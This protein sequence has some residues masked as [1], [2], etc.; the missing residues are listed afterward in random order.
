[1]TSGDAVP[2][3]EY[4]LRLPFDAESG[5][6]NTGPGPCVIILILPRHM[7]RS[8]VMVIV[9]A[10]Q[11]GKRERPYA[12]FNSAPPYCCSR[13]DRQWKTIIGLRTNTCS[14]FSEESSLRLRSAIARAHTS[15]RRLRVA[16]HPSVAHRDCESHRA[17]ST[18]SSD[19]YLAP[20]IIFTRLALS[21]VHRSGK[22]SPSP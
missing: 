20:P 21:Q 2:L 1:M 22:H 13:D 7:A 4:L 11:H 10:G 6:G 16:R 8:Q 17:L 3:G 9:L 19:G 5:A 18:T 15:Q 14:R 12:V